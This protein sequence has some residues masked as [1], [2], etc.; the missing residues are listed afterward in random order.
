MSMA[1]TP[2]RVSNA[3]ARSSRDA[4]PARTCYVRLTIR[5]T[6]A[7]LQKDRLLLSIARDVVRRVLEGAGSGRPSQESNHALHD[8]AQERSEHR[9][10]SA[11]PDGA[12]HE[13]GGVHRGVREDGTP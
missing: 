11:A 2:S 9:G 12:R 4:A 3:R 6:L 10:G 8:H 1:F 5:W 13:D 7:L